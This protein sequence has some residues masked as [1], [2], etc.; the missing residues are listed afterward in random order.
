MDNLFETFTSDPSTRAL[1]PP[2]VPL[3]TVDPY[4]SVWSPADRL[5]DS[6]TVHW[7]GA[8][9]SMIGLIRIDG[10][11]YRFCGP[12]P[13]SAPV[14]EQ[15]SLDV[16]PTR[17]IYTF[18]AA[19]VQLVVD[20]LTPLLPDDLDLLS[21]PV[22]YVTFTV[23]SLDG[24][25]HEVAVYY[26][27]AGEIAVN[28]ADQELCW[29][30]RSVDGLSARRIGMKDQKILNR[31]GD[32]LRIEW[33]WFYMAG[34]NVIAAAGPASRSAFV[35]NCVHIDFD[36]TCPRRADDRQPVL[37]SV[38]EFGPVGSDAVS[39][40]IL[41][42]Y[43]DEYSLEYMGN[44]LRPWWRRNG[45]EGDDMVALAEKEYDSVDVR[46]LEHDRKLMLELTKKGGVKYARLAALAFRQGISAH[47]LAADTNGQA[48]F[49][50]KENFSNGCIDTVDVTYPSS[51]FFLL[52]STELLRGQLRPIMDYSMSEK[53]A[54]PF[55][56]HDLGQY[57]K[58]NGQVYGENDISNQM[59]VEECG[60]M[61]VMITA[62]AQ[63]DGNSDFAQKYWPLITKWAEYLRDK[64][65]DPDNQLC[66]DDFAGHMAH[67]A[68]LAIKAIMG[69]GGYSLLCKMTGRDSEAAT[70]QAIAAKMAEGWIELAKDDNHYRLA[71]DQEG[72]WSQKYNLVWDKL[73][74]L[75]LFPDDVAKTEIASYLTKLNRYGLPLDNRSD[76]TKLD[77]IIWTATM[78]E[79]REDFVKFVEPLYDWI[80]ETQSRVPLTDW[81][82]TSDGKQVGFQARSVVAGVFIPLMK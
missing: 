63:R 61:L 49:M 54:F 77:W 36:E 27:V 76:Y 19:N 5:T 71:F 35:E 2:S 38:I 7:T 43:D 74:G 44:W 32:N 26:D 46:C 42:A 58:A 16:Q 82:W 56:P 55:A 57:P 51:P 75:N 50:S 18:N 62:M 17:T 72:S 3:I 67:N 40:H 33:G 37:A 69:I 65:L 34:K 66:T 6:R 68:N 1:R 53:W 45:M 81:Y 47:K 4:F 25:K 31:T 21:R 14:M 78:C 29:E 59:P 39:G 28:S 12:E 24:A 22:T 20:F 10:A 60:N 70:W 15:I 23:K 13:H 11:A 79:K 41:L 80:N 64:G 73:L 8:I 9:Q 52:Y 48:V 30:C